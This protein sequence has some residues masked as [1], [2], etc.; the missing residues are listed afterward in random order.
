MP[1]KAFLVPAKEERE[2]RGCGGARELPLRLTPRLQWLGQGRLLAPWNSCAR[3]TQGHALA[4][5]AWWAVLCC[6]RVRSCRP[7][8]Q[9]SLGRRSL[10]TGL[11]TFDSSFCPQTMM[12]RPGDWESCI[13]LFS[14]VVEEAPSFAEVRFSFLPCCL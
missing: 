5:H 12:N 14:S 3:V 9:G 1:S 6:Y 7:A 4:L 10:P 13:S 2:G 8:S 11:L